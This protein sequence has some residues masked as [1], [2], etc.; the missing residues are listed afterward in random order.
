MTKIEQLESKTSQ[1]KSD[2]DSLKS[3]VN[4]SEEQ[5]REKAQEI[6]NNAETETIKRDVEQ[7]IN[8]LESQTWEDSQKEIERAKTLLKNLDEITTLYNDIMW[9]EI[10]N[11]DLNQNNTNQIEDKDQT[12]N[13]PTSEVQDEDKSI[14]WT[15]G[16]WFWSAKERIWNQWS[17]IWNTDKRKEDWLKNWLRTAWFAVTWV[18]AVALLWKWAKKTWNWLFW[19]DDEEES[20]EK[21]KKKEK[22]FWD[23]WYG[24]LF[25]WTGIWTWIYYVVHGLNTGKWDL[26]HFFDWNHVT[27]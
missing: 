24:K 15:I 8:E 27:Y 21:Q 4:L 5:K 17:D 14:L 23:T 6:F 9:E 22:K 2:L 25:K 12:T 20:E 10:R 7:K 13:T 3:D 19:S 1:I 26:W 11:Q 16:N 18:W